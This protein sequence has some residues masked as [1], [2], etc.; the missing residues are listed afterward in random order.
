M[1]TEVFVQKKRKIV[2]GAATGIVKKDVLTPMSF[3]KF[4]RTPF[5]TEHF[6]ATASDRRKDMSMFE[7]YGGL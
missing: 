4:S 7:L 2:Q 3:A 5:F 1:F 6:R